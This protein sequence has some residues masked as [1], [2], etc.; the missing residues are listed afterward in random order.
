M[1]TKGRA[2]FFA[3]VGENRLMFKTHHPGNFPTMLWENHA[4]LSHTP[5][6]PDPEQQAPR[7]EIWASGGIEGYEG[8][9]SRPPLARQTPPPFQSLCWVWSHQGEGPHPTPR[10]A[11]WR[12]VEETGHSMGHTVMEATGAQIRGTQHSSGAQRRLSGGDGSQTPRRNR[13]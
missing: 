4:I 3:R 7:L 1:V 9:S 12:R 11:G 6:S 2:G 8:A 13:Y 5:F 10:S